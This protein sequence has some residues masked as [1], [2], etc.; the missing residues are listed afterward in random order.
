MP[1]MAGMDLGHA[2]VF[3]ADLLAKE[4]DLLLEPIV[5]GGQAYTGIDAVGCPAPG[6]GDGVVGQ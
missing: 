1:S 4:F 6:A 3:D 5:L 2:S